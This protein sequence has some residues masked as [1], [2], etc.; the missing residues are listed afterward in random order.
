MR[1]HLHCSSFQGLIFIFKVMMSLLRRSRRDLLGLD[2]EG[3]L[4]FFRVTLPKRY[5][6]PEACSELIDMAVA[7]KASLPFMVKSVF[8]TFAC[9]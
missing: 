2:F 9:T 6:K 4:K 3:T 1:P 7:A 8:T 5:L